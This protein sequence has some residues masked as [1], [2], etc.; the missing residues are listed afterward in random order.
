MTRQNIIL[1]V[2]LVVLLIV[3]TF[4][5]IDVRNME[6]V[7]HIAPIIQPV[8][9][10]VL[11][12]QTPPPSDVT[13]YAVG[14]IMLSRSV[15]PL[16]TAHGVDYPFQYVS[17]FLHTGDIDFANLEDPVTTG[18]VVPAGSMTFHAT[19]G[20]EQGIKNAGFTIL[21][22]A[23]NHI[24]NYGAEGIADTISGLDSFGLKHTGAGSTLAEANTPAILDVK[25]IHFALL[26]YNDT[27]VIPRDYAAS[28]NP[29][30]AG[31]DVFNIPLMQQT[32][33]SVRAQYAADVV[34]VAM[35]AGHEYHAQPDLDQVNFAH[36]AIDAGADM[37]LG[38]HPH[39]I[40][41]MEEYKGKYIFYSLGNFVFDQQFEDDVQQS[42]IAEEH[43]S[44]DL[45]TG[46]VTI[47]TPIFH[48]AYLKTLAQPQLIQQ[49]NPEYQ[50]IMARL[51]A[52]I[53]PDK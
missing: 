10:A 48:P 34:I 6:Y 30:R 9:T 1:G 35:H 42:V 40:E 38:A 17:S 23:N 11:P 18:P 47:S 39:V 45:K 52:A 4:V 2:S 5:I 15:A 19:P 3:G 49:D 33:R 16:L 12:V 32:V 53:V 24:P 28:N 20:S 27:D 21:G 46:A 26:A 8:P 41:P 7:S 50:I 43:F 25:G 51:T 44:K 29:P 22:L 14:D 37:V 31:T 36:A 13:L